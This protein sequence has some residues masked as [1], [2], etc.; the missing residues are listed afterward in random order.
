MFEA[1]KHFP[2]VFPK[3]GTPIV[4]LGAEGRNHFVD[5]DGRWTAG[6]RPAHVVRYPFILG[7][8]DKTNEMVVMVDD[9]APHFQ[10]D[11]GER[12][13]D[14]EGNPTEVV[15]RVKKFLGKYQEEVQRS[16]RLTEVLI[17]AGIMEER[18]IARVEGEQ[19]STVMK[20]FYVVDQAKLKA[21]PDETVLAWHKQ[22]TLALVHAH[23]ISL[24][25]LS[26]LTA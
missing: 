11:D 20:A 13:F 19:R 22:G 9:Q 25:N 24:T 10:T 7:K 5:D 16:M 4:L 21:L 3:S 23:L 17:E 6:Y 26:R 8:T 18:S 14:P 12:L 2:I 15:E 1:A